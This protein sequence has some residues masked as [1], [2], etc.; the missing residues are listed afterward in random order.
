MKEFLETFIRKSEWECALKGQIDSQLQENFMNGIVFFTHFIS[1]IYTP[2]QD[3]LHHFLLRGAAISCHRNQSGVDI[4][5]P[6]L[7]N[8][9]KVTYILI[10]ICNYTVSDSKY[11][12]ASQF[13]SPTYAG[14]EDEPQ[15]AYLSLY[16]QLGYSRGN[17]YNLKQNFFVN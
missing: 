6:V 13:V 11:K 9:G 15:A 14:I 7:L 2:R 1:V 17:I 16:M 8:D 10:Q 3:Q 12:H 4:I 5:I